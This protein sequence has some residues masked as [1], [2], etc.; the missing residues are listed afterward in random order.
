MDHKCSSLQPYE[1]VT[2]QFCR[3]EHEMSLTGPKWRCHQSCIPSGGSRAEF[4]PCLFQ[5]LE[6]TCILWLVAPS[7][8]FR[9]NNPTM[10]SHTGPCLPLSRRTPAITLSSPGQPPHPRILS[11][12]PSAEFPWLSRVTQSQVLWIRMG[13]P[14]YSA[15]HTYFTGMLS[16]FIVFFS[17]R[18]LRG[19]CCKE[20]LSLPRGPWGNWASETL[21]T[22]STLYCFV[23]NSMGQEFKTHHFFKNNHSHVWILMSISQR[24]R[25]SAWSHMMTLHFSF[26]PLHASLPQPESLLL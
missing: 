11:L 19:R 21:V 20:G 2:I 8:I 3:S 14:Y 22:C 23:Q 7:S 12:I 13:T 4:T 24:Q 9:A 25:E 18:N 16:V 6:D 10:L 15:S 5:F 17:L 26:S 1:L